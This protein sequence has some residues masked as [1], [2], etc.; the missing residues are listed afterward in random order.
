MQCDELPAVQVRL[1][2]Q[3]DAP[4]IATILHESFVEYER[5]YT[6]EGFAATT[7]DANQVMVRM[8][9]GPVWLA[10]RDLESLGTV[11]A[12]VKGKSVYIRGMAVLPAARGLKVGTRLLQH[13]ECWTFGQ[14]FQR[15]FLTT[16]PFLHTAIRLYENHGFRRAEG[17]Q[18]L[19][20]TP[21]FTMEKIVF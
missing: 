2:T 10:C 12:V 19:F 20:G 11:A 9:E 8:R 13:V 14:S 18:D 1:A 5:L 3:Q 17:D 16:T 15:L 7:P 21:L 4:T 6:R